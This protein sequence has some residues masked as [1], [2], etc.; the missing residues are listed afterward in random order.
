MNL[1]MNLATKNRVESTTHST[2]EVKSFAFIKAY[3]ESIEA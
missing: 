2:C 1:S 3:Q